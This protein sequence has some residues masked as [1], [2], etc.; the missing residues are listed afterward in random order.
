MAENEQPPAAS[1]VVHAL[2]VKLPDFW[3]HDPVCWFLQA[4]AVF[5]R[6]NVTRAHTK[7]DHVIMRLP[8]TTLLA[9]RDILLSVTPETDDPYDIL[10]TRLVGKFGPSKWHRINQLLD[11][12]DMGDNKPST[13]MD[14]ML[15]L[16]PPEEKPGDLFL[17]LFLRR[18][19]LHLR[20]QLGAN[21]YE[22]PRA[23]AEQADL[24]WDAR[25][26]STE[27]I[28]I[29]AVTGGRQHS[30][31]RRRSPSVRG[32]SRRQTPGPSSQ[33][34]YHERFGDRASRCR[35]PCNYPGNGLAASS[36]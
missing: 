14:S 17:G 12:P 7:Y 15:A 18:L 27:E 32:R 2:A 3:I 31:Q 11:Y 34:F 21:K 13:L 24:L 23:M 10:K 5:R 1:T 6:A 16:L 25:A 8:E 4:E 22:T 19:P 30:P 9:V 35:P 26:G 28:A 36:N 20:E 33:C 29:N